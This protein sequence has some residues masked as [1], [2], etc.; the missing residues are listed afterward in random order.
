MKKFYLVENEALTIEQMIGTM[1]FKKVNEVVSN[2]K[3]Y[4]FYNRFYDTV[5]NIKKFY[6]DESKTVGFTEN[7]LNEIFNEIDGINK[8]EKSERQSV[9]IFFSR[10]IDVRNSSLPDELRKLKEKYMPEFSA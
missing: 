5:E 6:I 8:N 1:N 3:D 4:I 2:Q 9:Y 10:K 7:E